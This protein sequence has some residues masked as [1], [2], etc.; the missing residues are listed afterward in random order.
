[1]HERIPI[2]SILFFLNFSIIVF[3]TEPVNTTSS[4][5]MIC[6]SPIDSKSCDICFIC[7]STFSWSVGFILDTK[8]LLLSKRVQSKNIMDSLFISRYILSNEMMGIPR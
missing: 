3:R 4:V 2:T 1:M 6:V 5:R 8:F 7:L